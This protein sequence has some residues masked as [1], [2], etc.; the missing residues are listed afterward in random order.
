VETQRVRNQK[1][2]RKL[3]HPHIFL[4]SRVT[5]SISSGKI[6]EEQCLMPNTHTHTH[7]ARRKWDSLVS[8]VGTSDNPSLYSEQRP[9][10]KTLLN[11]RSG[12]PLNMRHITTQEDNNECIWCLGCFTGTLRLPPMETKQGATFVS[13]PLPSNTILVSKSLRV[14]E[15]TRLC[16]GLYDS[17][18]II[19]P[20]CYCFIHVRI[21][22]F[23]FL[24]NVLGF[25]CPPLERPATQCVP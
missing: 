11:N 22:C 23:G 3:I 21:I 2:Y 19:C 15:T 6:G 12:I 5:V 18:Y 17:N 24:R 9:K 16:W 7:I 14:Q 20:I 1:V 25:V 13:W 8:A 4:W 10:N